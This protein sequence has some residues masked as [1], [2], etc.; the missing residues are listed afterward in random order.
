M[1]IERVVDE[2][3]R[4]TDK[5]FLN[6]EENKAI[7]EAHSI[8]EER[9][10]AQGAAFSR[11]DKEFLEWNFL[12]ILRFEGIEALLNFARTAKIQKTSKNSLRGG[13]C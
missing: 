10:K 13:Y 4:V 3:G 9:C 11:E 8:V 12:G 6:E 5:I 2:K 1:K 7:D